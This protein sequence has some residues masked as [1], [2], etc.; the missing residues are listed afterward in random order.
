M[1]IYKFLKELKLHHRI[2]GIDDRS[3]ALLDGFVDPLREE[4]DSGEADDQSSRRQ[5]LP[6]RC[7]GELEVMFIL[8]RTEDQLSDHAEDI[9]RSNHDR[10]S[11]SDDETAVE[12]VGMFERTEE[13]GHF[14]HEA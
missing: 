8:N 7:V 5:T 1:S 14:S 3:K 12:P 9:D 13:D 2:K 6:P 4:T 10:G 11:C